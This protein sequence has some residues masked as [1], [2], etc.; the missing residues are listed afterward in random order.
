MLKMLPWQ[1]Q[2]LNETKEELYNRVSL[3]KMSITVEELTSY[4]REPMRT[5][6]QT[7]IFYTTSLLFEEKPNYQFCKSLFRSAFPLK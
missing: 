4:I 1:V 7:Y 2:K 3:Q 5:A 6:L